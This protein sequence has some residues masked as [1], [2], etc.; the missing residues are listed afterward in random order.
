MN[1]PFIVNKE[2]QDL[3]LSHKPFRVFSCWNG[4]T[5]F[6]ASPLKN[7]TLQFRYTKNKK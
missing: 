2:A 5:V 3:I 6:T 7:K 1:F 4:V